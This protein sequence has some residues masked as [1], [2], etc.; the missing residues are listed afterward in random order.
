MLLKLQKEICV[1]CIK[2]EEVLMRNSVSSEGHVVQ[3]PQHKGGIRHSTRLRRENIKLKDY[4]FSG[5]GDDSV[6]G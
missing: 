2:N 5:T 3:D 6:A 1:T 4:T